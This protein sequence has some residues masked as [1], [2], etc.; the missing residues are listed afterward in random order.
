MKS[1]GIGFLAILVGAALIFW[2]GMGLGFVGNSPTYSDTPWDAF[3]WPWW[4]G[5]SFWWAF[6]LLILA[7]ASWGIGDAIRRNTS[8]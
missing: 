3:S 6:G 8:E 4:V 2:A 7:V 5:A 1:M